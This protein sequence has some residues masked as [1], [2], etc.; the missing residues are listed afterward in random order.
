MKKY[1]AVLSAFVL[2][3]LMACSK[4]VIAPEEIAKCYKTNPIEE[5]PWLND[6][7]A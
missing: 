4:E 3:I 6:V 5:L 7:S 1:F 2:I